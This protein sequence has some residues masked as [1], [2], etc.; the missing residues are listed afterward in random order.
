MI[1]AAKQAEVDLSDLLRQ[2]R[3]EGFV[4]EIL[5]NAPDERYTT[6]RLQ[7]RPKGRG[8]ASVATR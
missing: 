5:L 1:Q 6:S 3:E 4:G 7:S 2:L 8:G